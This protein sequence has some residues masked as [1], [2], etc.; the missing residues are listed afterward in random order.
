MPRPRIV[1]LLASATETIVALD[2]RDQLVAR[3]HECDFPPAIAALPAIT[4]TRLSPA[5]ASAA[6]DH[7]VRALLGAALSIYQ[8]DAEALRAAAPD[9]IVTQT[10]CDVCAVSLDD[11]ER[12]L[13]QWTGRR[14]E[15]VALAP[16]ALDDVFADI[17]RIGGAIGRNNQAE[18]LVSFMHG[19]MAD[20][21]GTVAG[22]K[23]RTVA[24]IEWIEPLMAGGNWMPELIARAGGTNLFGTAGRH[25]PWL[26]WSALC[27]ADPEIILVLPCGF[28]LARTRHEYAALAQRADWRALSAVRNGQTYLL[29]GSAL[30]NRPGPRLVESLDVLVEILHPRIRA[31]NHRGRFWENAGDPTRAA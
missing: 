17:R 7:D 6:I 26:D 5:R 2:A 13:G 4:S 3:S 23:R 27:N 15:I 14:P 8:V 25:S 11:V 19:A 28:D 1:S 29:D 21:A 10:Q 22:Q 9:V 12:A 24:A 18:S 16:N 30:F 20:A 31:P